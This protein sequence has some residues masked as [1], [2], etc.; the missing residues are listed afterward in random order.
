[1][2]T[3][4]PFLA[5]LSGGL[6]IAGA[7]IFWGVIVAAVVYRIRTG[8]LPFQDWGSVSSEEFLASVAA[9][10]SWWMWVNICF[11][12][13]IVITAFGLAGLNLIL[14]GAGDR[15]FAEFGLISFLL[16]TVLWLVLAAFNLSTVLWAANESASTGEVPVTFNGWPQWGESLLRMYMVFAYVSFAFY[17]AALLITELLASWASWASVIVGLGGGIS[18]IL[19]G[20]RF[21][22]PLLIHVIPVV[23]GIMLLFLK[24]Q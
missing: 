17:G 18:I 4:G 11:G 15:V 6:L 9:H 5:R 14:N 7:I 16:G 12:L 20:S 23:I 1:M 22:I 3:S 24:Q 19:G 13:G 21:A 8:S 10:R 2:T